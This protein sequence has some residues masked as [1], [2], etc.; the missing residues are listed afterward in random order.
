LILVD[1]HTKL[2]D[3]GHILHQKLHEFI[4]LVFAHNISNI[5]IYCALS[6]IANKEANGAH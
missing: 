6:F 4:N 3:V 5:F 2:A 1:L